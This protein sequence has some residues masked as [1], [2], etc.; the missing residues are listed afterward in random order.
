MIMTNSNSGGIDLLLNCSTDDMSNFDITPIFKCLENNGK[1]I[2]LYPNKV[3]I[4]RGAEFLTSNYLFERI[5][6]DV[7]IQSPEEIQRDIAG[8]IRRGKLSISFL[9]TI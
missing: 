8:M 6:P 4:E 2:E 9:I 1:Y 3:F 7:L 5:Q